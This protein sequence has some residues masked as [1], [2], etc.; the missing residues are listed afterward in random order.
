MEFLLNLITGVATG[1]T[2]SY[3]FLK[4]FLTKKKPNIAISEHISK[5]VVNDENS[6]LIKFVNLTDSEIFD[7]H[8]E[9][10]FY[11]PIGDYNGG[12]LQGKEINLKDNFLSYMPC[13]SSNDPHNLHAV[14]I[15]TTD[16]IEEMWSDTSS[17]IRLSIIAKHSLSGFNKV[18]IKDFLNKECITDRRFLSGNDLT[19]N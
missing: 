3:F 16:N 10:T 11:K 12:N 8:I 9:L 7:I 18:F 15:R 4:Y 17:F 1:I 19:V 13:N 14:R 5:Q 6:Y 2:A